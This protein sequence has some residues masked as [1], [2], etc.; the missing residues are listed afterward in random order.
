MPNTDVTP[1]LTIVSTST[2]DTVRSRSVSGGNA[3]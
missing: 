2:S 3:T 1:Q